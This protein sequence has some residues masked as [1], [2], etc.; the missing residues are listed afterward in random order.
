VSSDSHHQVRW[1]HFEL[2]KLSNCLFATVYT[3]V[4]VSGRLRQSVRKL[5]FL[6]KDMERAL[7]VS[8][9]LECG[10]VGI[11]SPNLVAIEFVVQFLV[12]KPEGRRTDF[13]FP[14]PSL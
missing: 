13:H 2:E 9:A 3:R 14:Q 5:I 12:E 7:R 10:Q 1:A 8:K 11:N 6:L 4:S